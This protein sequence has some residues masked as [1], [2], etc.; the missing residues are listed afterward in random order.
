ML[1]RQDVYF[2]KGSGMTL[3]QQLG[4]LTE[5]GKTGAPVGFASLEPGRQAA[6]RTVVS[7]SGFV[8]DRTNRFDH[9]PSEAAVSIDELA[10]AMHQDCEVSIDPGLDWH[11]WA[12]D[13]CLQGLAIA[14]RSAIARIIRVPLFHNSVTDFTLPD[15]FHRSA[16]LLLAKYPGWDG[17][18]TLCGQLRRRT[19]LSSVARAA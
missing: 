5:Q 8:I 16:E 9:E 4:S 10:V 13:L 2:P 18:P 11:L 6:D 12:T 17:I 19:E 3:A 15:A 1:V 7:Y 14:R